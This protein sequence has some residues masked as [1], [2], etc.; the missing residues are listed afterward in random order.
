MTSGGNLAANAAEQDEDGIA[1]E[2]QLALYSQGSGA[3]QAMT[4]QQPQLVHRSQGGL[5]KPLQ[6]SQVCGG[7][8]WSVG[9]S[10]AS[11]GAAS[12]WGVA[13]TSAHLS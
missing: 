8:F 6:A 2:N 4:Q 13:Q 1:P 12:K 5:A 3:L 7:P 9:P 11:P 10:H